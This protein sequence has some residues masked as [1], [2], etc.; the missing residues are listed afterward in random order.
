LTVIAAILALQ[1]G[2]FFPIDW[3]NFLAPGISSRQI[4]GST[5]S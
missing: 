3:G 2:H 5:Q 4:F 1:G